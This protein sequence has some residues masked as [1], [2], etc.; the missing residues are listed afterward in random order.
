MR[1]ALAE[2]SPAHAGGLPGRPTTRPPMRRLVKVELRKLTDTRSGRWLLVAIGLITA[3]VLVIFLIAG[4]VEDLTFASFVAAAATP[5]AVLLPVL[6]ILTVTSEWGQRTALVTFTLEPNRSRVIAAKLS[7]VLVVG[8]LAVV[9]S[10]ALAAASNVLGIWL[11]DGRG[12]WAF[13][14]SDLLEAGLGEVLA[15]L[16][17]FALGVLI[18]SSAG[19]IVTYFALPLMWQAA[20]AASEPIRKVAEWIDINTASAPLAM[21]DMTAEDWP[22]LMVA[23]VIWIVVPLAI[24]WTRLL[25]RELKSA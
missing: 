13:G 9:L 5:Q 10:L 1:N 18:T 4:K 14:V 6:G 7:A 11:R 16:Q 12:S 19:A 25:R 8:A 20:S 21:H 3:A 22:R 23:T 2:S 17:G 15:L 24:G